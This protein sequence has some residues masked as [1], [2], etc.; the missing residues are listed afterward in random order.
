EDATRLATQP[1]PTNA[2]DEQREAYD[3]F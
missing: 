1:P 2:N 3:V